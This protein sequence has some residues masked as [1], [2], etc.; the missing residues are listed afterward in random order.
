MLVYNEKAKRVVQAVQSVNQVFRNGGNPKRRNQKRQE[1][2]HAEAQLFA[3][4]QQGN[5]DKNTYPGNHLQESGCIAEHKFNHGC[6]YRQQNHKRRGDNLKYQFD[7]LHKNS[8][9]IKQPYCCILPIFYHF[10]QRV[11]MLSRP[12]RSCPGTSGQ[13]GPK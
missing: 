8:P 9:F 7:K 12:H 5:T 10:V 13:V 4:Y 2:E 3:A 11:T 6:Y 1:Q